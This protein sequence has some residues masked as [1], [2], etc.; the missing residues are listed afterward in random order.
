MLSDTF[1]TK[2][3]KCRVLYSTVIE[4]IEYF[5]YHP[6]MIGSLKILNDDDISYNY[7]YED[8]SALS[9]LYTQRGECD[10]IL[11]VKNGLF[12]DTYYCNIALLKDGIWITPRTPLLEG[13]QRSFLLDKGKIFPKDIGIKTLAEYESIRLFNSIL[14]FGEIEL[15]IS[16][17]KEG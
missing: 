3:I 9:R 11:I 13:T 4:R 14:G 2:R 7:K 16:S 8:R 12:T 15:P 1:K 10:D 6:K 5:E 17:I